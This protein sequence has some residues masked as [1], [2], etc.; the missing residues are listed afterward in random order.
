LSSCDD[1]TIVIPVKDERDGL[2]LVLE[3]IVESGFDLGDSRR[4]G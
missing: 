3:E 2:K 1:L 4:R